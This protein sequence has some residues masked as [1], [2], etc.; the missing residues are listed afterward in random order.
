MV[1]D[2]AYDMSGLP[3]LARVAAFRTSRPAHQET[4]ANRV[5][6]A[7]VRGVGGFVDEPVEANAGRLV[8]D[9]ASFGDGAV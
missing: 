6:R 1:G 4:T 3:P 2:L 5:V 9:G 8:A 7:P